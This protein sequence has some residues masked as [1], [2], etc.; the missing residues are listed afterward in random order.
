MRDYAHEANL[1]KYRQQDFQ[2][3]ELSVIENLP[4][5][6]AVERECDELVGGLSDDHG[7]DTE[8]D[9][10]E[11]DGKTDRL[12]HEFQLEYEVGTAFYIEQVQV[13]MREGRKHV[14]EAE[15]LQ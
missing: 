12:L 15:D 5:V 13:D 2:L 1:H 4:G 3:L 6:V 7:I 9:G 10:R 14:T 11:Q 8:G